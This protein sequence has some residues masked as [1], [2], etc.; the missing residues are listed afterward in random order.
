[1]WNVIAWQIWCRRK[2]CRR[3]KLHVCHLL[4]F[5]HKK[6]DSFITWHVWGVESIKS[7]CMFLLIDDF[8]L[9]KSYSRMNYTVFAKLRMFKGTIMISEVAEERIWKLYMKMIC[10][11]AQTGSYSLICNNLTFQLLFKL[12]MNFKI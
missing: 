8:R 5:N 3:R 2:L 12:W 4:Q 9:W 10:C 11:T 7:G 6:K 1:M